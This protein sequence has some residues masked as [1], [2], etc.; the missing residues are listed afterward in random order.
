MYV[1]SVYYV[2]RLSFVA[3]TDEERNCVLF[4]AM[5][6]HVLHLYSM[7]FIARTNRQKT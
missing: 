2:A 1:Y 5:D 6:K 3:R 7:C 4:A